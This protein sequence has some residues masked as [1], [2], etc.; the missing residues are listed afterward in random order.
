[1][2][3]A[4]LAMKGPENMTPREAKRFLRS[5]SSAQIKEYNQLHKKHK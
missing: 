1:M 4:E 2:T 5:I 3:G